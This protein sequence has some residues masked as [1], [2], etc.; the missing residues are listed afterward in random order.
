MLERVRLP[1]E[2]PKICCAR[3]RTSITLYLSYDYVTWYI[4]I[5][6]CPD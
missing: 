6:C 5:L 4:Y 3:R 1:P 2:R